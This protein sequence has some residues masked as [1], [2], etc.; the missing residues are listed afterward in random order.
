MGR[1]VDWCGRLGSADVW[2]W[3]ASLAL[4]ALAMTGE[5]LGRKSETRSAI[6]SAHVPW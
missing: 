3:I 2:F 4:R 6:F 5:G 1:E